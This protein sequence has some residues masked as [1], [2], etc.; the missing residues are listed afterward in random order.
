M[1]GDDVG[2]F[3]I[4]VRQSSAFHDLQQTVTSKSDTTESN[5]M[6]SDNLRMSCVSYPAYDGV[7]SV[8]RIGR[9]FDDS[10][11]TV[12]FGQGV[13]AFNSIA[14]TNFGLLLVVACVAIR[15]TVFELIMSWSLQQ[16]IFIIEVNKLC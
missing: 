5:S 7:E 4:R 1:K 14:N 9:V 16:V 11:C 2:G 6:S 15:H 13:F 12:G 3:M 8:M 10:D